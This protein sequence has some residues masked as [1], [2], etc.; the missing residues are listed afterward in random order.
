MVDDAE[1][2]GRRRPAGT[3]PPPA[4]WIDG[5]TLA[6]RGGDHAEAARRRLER[7]LDAWLRDIDFEEVTLEDRIAFI[8]S[9][10]M[11]RIRRAVA[12]GRLDLVPHLCGAGIRKAG[13]LGAGIR[14]AGAAGPLAVVRPKDR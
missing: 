12:R 9:V 8:E 7:A 14:A 1:R 2:P 11:H 3:A 10:V 4:T 13:E 6:M 5:L